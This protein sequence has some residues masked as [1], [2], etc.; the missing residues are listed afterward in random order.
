MN[1]VV[2]ILDPD[3]PGVHPPALDISYFNRSS[4]NCK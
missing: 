1:A 3:E 2:H 4:D